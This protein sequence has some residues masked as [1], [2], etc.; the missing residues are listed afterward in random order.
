M[1]K[2]RSWLGL[3]PASIIMLG[4]FGSSLGYGI[5]QSLG[6]LPF[7]DQRELSLAA[8]RNVL[9]GQQLGPAFFVVGQLCRHVWLGMH[10][11]GTAQ[12]Y[13]RA[14]TALSRAKHC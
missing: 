5:A 9:V 1:A 8:Y 2:W 7:L 6:W 13:R 12:Q 10:L 11:L 3:A 14:P 4:L